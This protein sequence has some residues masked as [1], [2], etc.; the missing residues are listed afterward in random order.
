MSNHDEVEEVVAKPESKESKLSKS[1]LSEVEGGKQDLV[2]EQR[3]A[4]RRLKDGGH[5]GI[6]DTFGKQILVDDEHSDQ[7]NG[8]DR[9]SKTG[10]SS[11]ANQ[12]IKPEDGAVKESQLQ[13][14]N[15][16]TESGM[17]GLIKEAKEFWQDAAKTARVEG[18]ASGHLSALAAETM[19]IGA[20]AF[21]LSHNALNTAF[22]EGIAKPASEYWQSVA[23]EGEQT[24]GLSGFAEK[25]AGKT[26]DGLLSVSGIASVEDGTQS[27]IKDI[28]EGASTEQ[29]KHDVGWLAVDSAL[30]AATVVPGVTGI[31]AMVEGGTLFRTAAAGSEIAGMTA[32]GTSLGESVAS[33]LAQV[34]E[35]TLPKSGE[36][37]GKEHLTNFVDNIRKVASEYGIKI[38]QGGVIGESK[39]GIDA[40]D[41]SSIIGG[42]HEV[43][44][45]VQQLQTRATALEAAAARAGK[46]ISELTQAERAEAYTQVVKPFE[47]AAYNQHEMWAGQAH[48]WGQTSTEYGDVL[49][50]NLKSF[51]T[52]LASGT[53]PE[54]T[55][56]AASRAY[57][58]LPNLLG[59]SQMEIAKNLAAPAADIVH[60]VVDS[61]W[62]DKDL[63]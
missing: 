57:G 44:H 60:S 4:M 47:E 48:S 18:G 25:V 5:S 56:S 17:V 14:P 38:Q 36:K 63:F 40:I 2:K 6:T 12:T 28:N 52:A 33:K 54:A 20:E 31:K 23:H 41:Y 55:V 53:I 24:G 43:A 15:S 45:V 19:T 51:E 7:E 50:A 10:D 61:D 8:K 39:G 59:R 46:T 37:I 21:D 3:A 30:T 13:Q 62:K 11:S 32:T 16:Q 9:G 42:P 27:V 1:L 49:I 26:M 34:I 58:E 29:L 22:P 35:D